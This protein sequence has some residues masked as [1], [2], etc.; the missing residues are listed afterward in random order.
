MPS[1]PAPAGTCPFAVIDRDERKSAGIARQ[2]AHPASGSLPADGFALSRAILRNGDLK[3]GG[4]GGEWPVKDP[5]HAPVFFLDGE[6]HKKKRSTIARLFTPRAIEGQHRAVMEA[7]TARLLDTLRRDKR[8]QLDAASW[9]LAVEVAASIVG[10]TDGDMGAMAD[11][12]EGVFANTELHTLPPLRRFFA[13]LRQKW[14]VL[15]FFRHDVRPVI[16]A[17]KAAPRADLI[18]HLV[19]EGYPAPVIL[20]ECMTYAAA[21]MA[22]TR[23]FI[24]MVAWHLFERDDLRARF[25]SDDEAGQIALLE[26]ILRLEPVATY[27]YRKTGDHVPPA[28]AV[29]LQ[30]RNNYA[31]DLRAANVDAAAAGPCPFAIDPDRAAKTGETGAFLSFGDGAHRCPGAQVALHE[32]RVFID[33]LLRVPGVRLEQAPQIGWNEALMSYELRGAIVACD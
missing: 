25:L 5:M 23:E 20:M 16:A 31:L 19:A 8:F 29:R 9:T 4:L 30:P 1:S 28:L 24:T 2:H 7:T 12:L 14:R 32:S 6:L 22:T 3:Q 15:Q 17:R 33:A 11:R 18:S 27:L 10:I 21:G 26:E 13:G